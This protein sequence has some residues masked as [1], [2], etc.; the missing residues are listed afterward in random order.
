MPPVVVDASALVA[1][2]IRSPAASAVEESL[3]GRD[4]VAPDLINEEVLSALRSLRS[5][6]VIAD[7]RAERAVA[8]LVRAPV[9]RVLTAPLLAGMWAL[10]DRISSYD[11]AYVVLA[12]RLS[13]GLVTRDR[14]LGRAHGLGIEIVTIDG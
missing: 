1:V 5:R 14:A 8:N 13:C 10:R 9:R 12:Q 3:A 6:G 4:L 7:D 2:V 11:A